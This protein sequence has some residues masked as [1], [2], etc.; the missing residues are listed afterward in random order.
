MGEQL[1][2]DEGLPP[3]TASVY[4]PPPRPHAVRLVVD[5]DLKRSRLTVFFRPIL[6]I[7]HVIWLNLWKIAIYVVA[8][9]NWWVTLFAGRT[10]EDL[11]TFI[12]RYE[13]YQ[14]HLSAYQTF[15][16]N[17]YPGFFGR[18][19]SYPV[20]LVIEPARPQRRLITLL[21]LILAIPA[22]ILAYVFSI[23][24]AVV[25][26]IGWFVCLILGRMPKGMRD[27]VAYCRRYRSQTDGYILLLTD[28]YPSLSA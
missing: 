1:P 9:I 2:P 14:T 23:V 25:A 28:R 11:H 13:R 7:P 16:A 3:G 20:D 26:I 5:D 21:R 4:A 6:A 17:P 24:T 10:P 12:G 27:L 15:L 22:F 8:F 18:E 19:G